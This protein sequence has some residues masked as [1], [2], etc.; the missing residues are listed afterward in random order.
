MV[1]VTIN[2]IIWGRQVVV[3]ARLIS[4]LMFTSQ[5]RSHQHSKHIVW[6]VTFLLWLQHHLYSVSFFTTNYRLYWTLWNSSIT[7]IYS[8]HQTWIA[9]A[10]SC[11]QSPQFAFF[12]VTRNQQCNACMRK[13]HY[14]Y[15]HLISSQFL[16]S[17]IFGLCIVSC[18]MRHD[19]A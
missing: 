10:L 9:N 18:G 8:S 3:I 16:F 19:V 6:G 4:S 13:H 15:P 12:S 17:I 2:S 14:A 5:N 7:T 1:L 11:G